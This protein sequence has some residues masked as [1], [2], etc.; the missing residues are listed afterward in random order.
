MDNNRVGHH[1]V[2]ARDGG[3]HLVWLVLPEP[4]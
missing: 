3:G 2:E 1:L 4:S